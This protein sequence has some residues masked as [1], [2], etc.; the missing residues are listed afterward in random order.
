MK[1]TA[2]DCHV[3]YGWCLGLRQWHITAIIPVNFTKF[4]TELIVALNAA[5]TG[6]SCKTPVRIIF[7][8]KG[9]EIQLF[10]PE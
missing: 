8:M 6:L 2:F 7:A 10:L 3:I 4:Q 9:E 1:I 5:A